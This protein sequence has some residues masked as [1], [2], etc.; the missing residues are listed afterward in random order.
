MAQCDREWERAGIDTVPSLAELLKDWE[1]YY[2]L[3]ES[4][5]GGP[6]GSAGNNHPDPSHS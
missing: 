6:E 1:L 3:E 2:S 5:H 4:D